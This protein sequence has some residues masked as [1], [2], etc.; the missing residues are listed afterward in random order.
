MPGPLRRWLTGTHREA[1]RESPWVL[2]GLPDREAGERC[3]EGCRPDLWEANRL[4]DTWSQF[5]TRGGQT[6][7][8][9][10]LEWSK[11]QERTF[12]SRAKRN[13]ELQGSQG[14][15]PFPLPTSLSDLQGQ[16]SLKGA[17]LGVSGARGWIV[18]YTE[19]S[20]L[21]ESLA[22]DYALYYSYKPLEKASPG[23]FYN[24]VWHKSFYKIPPPLFLKLKVLVL[25]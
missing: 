18:L 7:W 19:P 13:F 12:L 5:S 20:L 10:F 21:T 3:S 6:T 1:L 16:Y 23:S 24:F 8:G 15:Q 2:L 9:E 25:L 11:S 4:G 22:R 17:V 14:H